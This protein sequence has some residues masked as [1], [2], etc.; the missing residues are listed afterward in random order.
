MKKYLSLAP[1]SLAAG[2]VFAAVPTEVTTAISDGKADMLT[3]AGLMLAVFIA[4][5]G[6]KLIRKAAH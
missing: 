1:L 4:L 2:S 6:F 5:V 3:V